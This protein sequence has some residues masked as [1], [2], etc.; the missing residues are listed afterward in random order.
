MNILYLGPYR[1]KTTIG[2][3]S[4]LILINLLQNKKNKV[5]CAPL[6]TDFN[7][8]AK[9][10]DIDSAVLDSEKSNYEQYDCVIQHTT[11]S[12][13]VP[14]NG[15]AKN[16]L[17][18]IMSCNDTDIK[19]D[20]IKG[21]DK[22][23][24]D[25][26]VDY[27]RLTQHKMLKN[28]VHVYDYA[29]GFTSN[30]QTKIDLGIVNFYKKLYYIGDY[31]ANKDNILNVCKSFIANSQKDKNVLLLFITNLTKPQKDQLESYISKLYSLIYKHSYAKAH[32]IGM[33]SDMGTLL[34]AHRTGDVFINLE[35]THSNTLNLKINQL[36][37]KE[38]LNFNINDYGFK[39]ENNGTFFP[40]GCNTVTESS[41]HSKISNYLYNNTSDKLSHSKK[42]DINE[43]L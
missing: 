5:S 21:F 10:K 17:L 13:A 9:E 19:V 3:T 29:I 8:A 1:Q 30:E 11:I 12:S 38:L 24:V 16:I 40:G 4:Q 33:E 39:Y 7:K 35:D 27:A 34:L 20:I 41:I 22:I 31:E 6:Y 32:V 2:L 36:Y 25:N 43:L 42:T 37:N 28:K 18:P 15:V 23:L 26:Q 14:I